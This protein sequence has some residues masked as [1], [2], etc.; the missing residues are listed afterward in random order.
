MKYFKDKILYCSSNR[1]LSEILDSYFIL[2]FSDQYLDDLSLIIVDINDIELFDKLLKY[3][4]CCDLP[5]VLYVDKLDEYLIKRAYDYGISTI[6]KENEEDFEINLKLE[7]LIKQSKIK[8]KLKQTNNNL[9][10]DEH[11]LIE[12][13]EKMMIEMFRY[14]QIDSAKHMANLKEIVYILLKEYQKGH[15]E[16]SDKWIDIVSVGASYHDIGKIG[17]S[18]DLINAKHKLSKEEYAIVKEHTIIGEKIFYSMLNKFN[19]ELIYEWMAIC[20]WHHERIDGLGYPDG[21]SEDLI[22]LSAKVVGI[23][24]VFEALTSKRSY[25]D[26][27]SFDEAFKMIKSGKCGKFDCELIETLGRCRN[28]LIYLEYNRDM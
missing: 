1:K 10:Q 18:D 12:M 15:R 3:K 7:T 8:S 2:E 6:I 21:L 23:A 19:N 26:G 27:L 5:I 28:K 20:R 13:M 24:D 16:I 9:N 22:P 14:H 4:N 11:K 25:K 17:I